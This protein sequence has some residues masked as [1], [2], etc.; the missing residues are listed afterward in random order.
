MIN[1]IIFFMV[2][3]GACALYF[4]ARLAN[5]KNNKGLLYFSLAIILHCYNFQSTL[6]IIGQ[7]LEEQQENR[8]ISEAFHKALRTPMGKPSPYAAVQIANRKP[9]DFSGKPLLKELPLLNIRFTNPSEKIHYQALGTVRFIA[10]T[11]QQLYATYGYQLLD[12]SAQE[13]KDRSIVGSCDTINENGHALSHTFQSPT[14]PLEAFYVAC[15]EEMHVAQYH[16]PREINLIFEQ[17]FRK[18]GRLIDLASCD[19]EIRCTLAGIMRLVEIGVPTQQLLKIE[20]KY[21]NFPLALKIFTKSQAGEIFKQALLPQ[22]TFLPTGAAELFEMWYAKDS[23][24]N[25]TGIL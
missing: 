4:L 8:L 16:C 24:W 18:I 22:D 14:T 5:A 2:F 23:M 21:K 10:K 17:K 1:W 15:H 3:S 6:Q 20:G 13:K 19:E 9:V 12:K 7:Y 11:R 25:I